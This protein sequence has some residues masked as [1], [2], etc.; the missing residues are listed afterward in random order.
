MQ[1]LYNH[2]NG[3]GKS[4][5]RFPGLPPARVVVLGAGQV[6]LHAAL[7]AAVLGADVYLFEKDTFRIAQI[8]SGLPSNVHI[9]QIDAVSLE[10]YVCE[11]DLV[12][13]AATVP[14]K[15]SR[16]L[17][18]RKMISKMQKGSVIVDVTVFLEGAVET[19]DRYSS[20][21][22]PVWEVDGVIHYAVPNIPGTVAQTASRALASETLPYVLEIADHGIP[23]IF[24]VNPIL[25]QAVSTIHGK[26][27]WQKAG[28][29]QNRPWYPPQ[30]AVTDVS[31]ES[32]N[33]SP[34]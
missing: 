11:A 21:A 4:L 12:I 24:S 33:G 22:D 8:A 27:T 29:Y 6:G 9:I 2:R 28:E 7:T 26:L 18:D 19:I 31:G 15:S 17:I 25:L 20:H 23:E 30:K 5:I 10:A 3:V 13:N 1:F 16:H 34:P 32:P 14:P